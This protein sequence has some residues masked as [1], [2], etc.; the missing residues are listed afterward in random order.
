[1]GIS[2]RRHITGGHSRPTGTSLVGIPRVTILLGRER[3]KSDAN[4]LHMKTT[5]KIKII[6]MRN[7]WNLESSVSLP[8]LLRIAFKSNVGL[9]KSL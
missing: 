5:Y 4:T 6:M 7:I 2:A 9:L 1:V 3:C 8:H